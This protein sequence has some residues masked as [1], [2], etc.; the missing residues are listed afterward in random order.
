MRQRAILMM[1]LI[2]AA[3][4]GPSP[5]FVG[6]PA[7]EVT[8]DDSRFRVFKQSGSGRVE[9]HRISLEP[10]PSLVLTLEKAYRAIEFATGC[11]VVSGSLRG[12]QAIILADVDCALP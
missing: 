10:L 12:D 5:G 9:A 2:A 1:A 4:D 7:R 6:L 11:I 8:I 3:C